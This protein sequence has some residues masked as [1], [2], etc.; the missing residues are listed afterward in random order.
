MNDPRTTMDSA[1]RLSLPLE[2]AEAA[3]G[4]ETCA[5]LVEQREIARARGDFSAVTD[6]DVEIRHHPH[7]GRTPR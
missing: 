4:C 6:A 1:A 5:S 7:P 2:R 3:P